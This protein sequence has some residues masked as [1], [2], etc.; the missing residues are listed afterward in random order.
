MKLIHL[1]HL[2]TTKKVIINL[3]DLKSKIVLKD[4]SNIYS[5]DFH[6]WI[7][8]TGAIE[9]SVWINRLKPLIYESMKKAQSDNTHPF[10]STHKW[11]SNRI[12]CKPCT[13]IYKEF[14]AQKT[15]IHIGAEIAPLVD[16]FTCC[17]PSSPPWSFTLCTILDRFH[18]CPPDPPPRFFTTRL[19][20]HWFGNFPT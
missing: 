13:A 2:Y 4:T 12:A 18:R 14:L 8:N 15:T 9:H 5:D 6:T 19:I 17:S 3:F 16:K 1:E 20:P 7:D 10:W 11:T